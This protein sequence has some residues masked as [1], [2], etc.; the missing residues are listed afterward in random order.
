MSDTQQQ[1]TGEIVHWYQGYRVLE[2]S[3]A[4]QVVSEDGTIHG[5]DA[6]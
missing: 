5:H 3:D 1:G 6:V 2:F 4:I